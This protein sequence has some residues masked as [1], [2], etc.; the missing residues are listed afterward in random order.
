[1]TVRLAVIGAGLMGRS[2]A[3]ATKGRTF[4]RVVCVCDPAQEQGAPLARELGA[5]WQADYRKVLENREVDAVIVTTPLNLHRTI[6]LDA[7]RAGNHV[8]C[9]KPLAPNTD[10]CDE[11]I[12]ASRE[13]GYKLMVGHI[14][15][16]DPKV[17]AMFRLANSGKLGIAQAVISRRTWVA[18]T[19]SGWRTDR[20]VHG[21]ILFEV[22]VHEIDL[23]CEL[24]GEPVQVKAECSDVAEHGMENLVSILVQFPQRRFANMTY[25]VRDLWSSHSFEVHCAA[26]ALRLLY[27][28]KE[29]VEI[30]LVGRETSEFEWTTRSNMAADEIKAFC[31]AVAS[32]KEVPV[33]G[34]AGRRAIAVAEAAIRSYESGSAVDI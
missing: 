12:R 15:R 6:T 5:T 4:G 19:Y 30:R 3:I 28:P 31:L 14:L 13:T 22:A 9:E 16:F 2:L 20:S 7:L 18:W 33:P 21:G 23:V 32:D 25:G 24:L 34:S 1:M 29:G 27:A 8:L 17:Q 11:M 10:A 26:G